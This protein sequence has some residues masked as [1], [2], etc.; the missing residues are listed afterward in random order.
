MTPRQQLDQFLL[1]HSDIEIFEVILHDL[2]GNHRGK[3]LPREQIGSS[4]MADT[5]CRK[6]PAR[7]IAGVEILKS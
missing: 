1:D 5:K 6:P 4:L 2:N 7:W 3:W